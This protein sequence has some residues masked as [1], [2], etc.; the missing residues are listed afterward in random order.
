MTKARHACANSERD[1]AQARTHFASNLN[2]SINYC[3]DGFH[4]IVITASSLPLPLHTGQ[5]FF[6]RSR[7]CSPQKKPLPW[8]YPHKWPLLVMLSFMLPPPINAGG[9]IL[10]MSFLT[11]IISCFPLCQALIRMPVNPIHS[12]KYHRIV[13]TLVQ[14][15]LPTLDK[16]QPF[17]LLLSSILPRNVQNVH[18]ATQAH[19]HQPIALH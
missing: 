2:C 12:N 3:F 17:F 10:I 9:V 15:L 11:L 19:K 1:T 8:Q 4:S 13:Y 16:P 18:K 7:C 5:S 6:T 14:A